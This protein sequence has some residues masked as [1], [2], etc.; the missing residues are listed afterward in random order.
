MRTQRRRGTHTDCGASAT[1]TFCNSDSGVEGGARKTG[2]LE[3]AL[4]SADDDERLLR[5]GIERTKS[6]VGSSGGRNDSGEIAIGRECS[7]T[8]GQSRQGAHAYGAK[9][10][11]D[12]IESCSSA[13]SDQH[14]GIQLADLAAGVVGRIARAVC[15]GAPLADE[16]NDIAA[17]WRPLLLDME[18][19]YVMVSD[20]KLVDM[21]PA[22]FGREYIRAG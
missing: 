11:L 22:L 18:R 12:S 15:L 6:S 20:A 2:L 5:F 4:L 19:H 3:R 1:A 13:S 9:L 17:A 10:Q 16:L 7:S 21:A 14:L 8:D